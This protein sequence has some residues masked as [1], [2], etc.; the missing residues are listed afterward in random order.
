MCLLFLLPWVSN[1]NAQYNHYGEVGIGAPPNNAA[2]LKILD[3]DNYNTTTDPSYDRR[4]VVIEPLNA[5]KGY[6]A[7]PQAA[8]FKVRFKDNTNPTK[9]VKNVI[10]TYRIVNGTA[11]AG[12][13]FSYPAG[14]NTTLDQGTVTITAMQNE[15]P[16]I[17]IPVIDDSIIEADETFSVQLLSAASDG[18]IPSREN[19]STATVFP[20]GPNETFTIVDNDRTDPSKLKVNMSIDNV[21][22]DRGGAARTVTVSLPTGVSISAATPITVNF[23]ALT[24]ATASDYA[25]SATSVQLTSTDP[26]KTITVTAKCN[27]TVAT[28]HTADLAATLNATAVI[29][30][31]GNL[32]V[33]VSPASLALTIKKTG[34]G[35]LITGVTTVCFGETVTLTAPAGGTSWQWYKNGTAI[36]TNGTSSTYTTLATEAAGTS[37]SYTVKVTNSFGCERTSNAYVVTVNPKPTAP[38]ISTLSDTDICGTG[39][40]VINASPATPPAGVSYQWYKDGSPL[41][42]QTGGSLTV[43]S[44][45]GTGAYTVRATHTTGCYSDASPAITFT[46]Q[47]G[48]ATPKPVIAPNPA[49]NCGGGAI[50][51]ATA[52]SGSYS[53]SATYIWYKR[54]GGAGG[55]VTEVYRTTGSNV[56]LADGGEYTVIVKDP[57]CTS[58]EADYVTVTKNVTTPLAQPVIVKDSRPGTCQGGSILLEITNAATYP[59]GTTFQWYRD[60]VGGGAIAGAVGIVHAA[61]VTGK[62]WA[63]A[64]SANGLCTSGY[65]EADKVDVTITGTSTLTKPVIDKGA[66]AQYCTGGTVTLSVTAASQVAGATYTW[67]SDKRG[68]PI[69][70]GTSCHANTDK[71]NYWVI[72]SKDGCPGP[73]SEKTYVTKSTTTANLAAPVLSSNVVGNTMCEDGSIE[74][75]AAG[76]YTN[77]KYWWFLDNV[78][79]AETTANVYNAIAAG[80]YTVKVVSQ[81]G[82]NNGCESPISNEITVNQGSQTQL[83]QPTIKAVDDNYDA[84]K[85]GTVTLYVTNVQAGVTYQWYNSVDGKITGATG[86]G[87]S[88]AASKTADYWV[89]ATDGTCQSLPSG[90][91]HVTV[92]SAGTN[93]PVKPQ[94]KPSSP[95]TAQFCT[96]GSVTL[97]VDNAATYT[98]HTYQWH[99]EGLGIISGETGASIAVSVEDKYWVVVTDNNSGCQSVA[100]E[101][102]TVTKSATTANLDTPVIAT[103]GGNTF[104]KTNGTSSGSVTI[105]VTNMTD[106]QPAYNNGDIKFQWHSSKV[107]AIAGATEPTYHASVEATYWVV[108]TDVNSNC[109][110]KPSNKEDITEGN[111]VNDVAQPRIDTSGGVTQICT[112][113]SMDLTA[114]E[115]ASGNTYA[116]GVSFKWYRNGLEIAGK[117]GSVINI[118]EN[119]NYTVVAIG[120]CQSLPSAGK[121]ITIGG[122]PAPTVTI[123][124][125]NSNFT[126][127]SGG[128][129]TLEA[130]ALPAGAYSYQWYKDGAPHGGPVTPGNTLT[131]NQAGVYTVVAINGTCRSLQAAP[132]ANVVSSGG[133]APEQPKVVPFNGVTHICAGGSVELKA[134]K[135][136]NSEYL[137]ASDYTFIWFNNGTIVAGE[138]QAIL[139]ATTGGNYTVKVKNDCGESAESTPAVTVTGPDAG[140]PVLVKPEIVADPL[141]AEMCAN[142]SVKLTARQSTDQA[143]YTG[144][145]TYRWFKDGVYLTTTTAPT[146]YIQATATGKY[147][148]KVSLGACTSVISDGKDVINKTGGNVPYTPGIDASSNSICTN[149]MVIL[150]TDVNIAGATYEWYRKDDGTMATTS[151]PSYSAM[152]DGTYYVIVVDGGCRSLPSPDET[153]IPGGGPAQNAPTIVSLGGNQVCTNGAVALQATAVAPATVTKYVW[154]KDGAEVG[155]T[156]TNIYY[157]V[158]GGTYTVAVLEGTCLSKQ[159]T[160]GVVIT[161]GTDQAAGKPVISGVSNEICDNVAIKLTATATAG[162]DPITAYDWYLDGAFKATT[163][164]NEYVAKDAGT[165]TVIA[166]SGVGANAC[167]S[168]PSAGYTVNKTTGTACTASRIELVASSTVNEGQNVTLTAKLKDGYVANGAI[169]VDLS[170]VAGGTNP[171]AEFGACT[172]PYNGH[173]DFYYAGGPNVT[174]TIADGTSEA[175]LV[176][177][178]CDD[179]VAEGEEDFAI[180]GKFN[181]TVVGNSPRVITI[182]DD[183]INPDGTLELTWKLDP[184]CIEGVISGVPYVTKGNPI[185]YIVT[186]VHP[187]KFPVEPVKVQNNVTLDISYSGAAGRYT[188]VGSTTI[189][190]GNSSEVVTVPTIPDNVMESEPLSSFA[191][192]ASMGVSDPETVLIHWGP[193]GGKPDITLALAPV[194][195]A[196]VTEGDSFTLTASVDGGFLLPQ[197]ITLTLSDRNSGAT[198][199]A[200]SG[201]DYDLV[202]SI[203][204]PQNSSSANITINTI[205]NDLFDGTRKLQLNATADANDVAKIN[206]Q[207]PA[208]WPAPLADGLIFDNDKPCLTITSDQDGLDDVVTLANITVK[209]DN[210]TPNSPAVI[211]ALQDAMSGNILGTSYTSLHSTFPIT[212]S[213]GTPSTSFALHSNIGRPTVEQMITIYNNIST[214]VATFG[215]VTYSI[216]P[217]TV[218]IGGNPA[219]VADL[220]CYEPLSVI[221][222]DDFDQDGL[223]NWLERGDSNNIFHCTE[224][225]NGNGTP[226]EWDAYDPNADDDGDG[227][228]NWVE[229]ANRD[230]NPYNDYA[231]PQTITSVNGVACTPYIKG[232]VS[233]LPNFANLDSDGDGVPDSVEKWTD[234]PYDDNEG[235]INIHPALSF[236]DDG[237]GNDYLYIENIEKYTDNL[238]TVFDRQGI[239]VFEQRNYTNSAGTGTD[240]F[241]GV[242][243]KGRKVKKVPMGT[244][245]VVV[246]YVNN[247]GQKKHYTKAVEIRY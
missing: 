237:V 191:F 83:D 155:R 67:Y 229:D 81:S 194:A 139:H 125:S 227:I 240:V 44:A 99:R 40:A 11:T 126:L 70:T 119:G 133:T 168:Q 230:G 195:P 46:F 196:G 163:V 92:A 150:T 153:I 156:N 164:T 131:V 173:S 8:Q 50:L 85:G 170:V 114:V 1:L 233:C 27:S 130:N 79:V 134:V 235:E 140:A 56:F 232:L 174:L 35:N 49:S 141:N 231:K 4:R 146:S 199:A 112:G 186:V 103:E 9:A 188:P 77:V 192:S 142:G 123:K 128:S 25:Y 182:V 242:P 54:V 68:G 117:T 6:E 21:N 201:V 91:K 69:N 209:I 238:V 223:P 102:V 239:V 206:T 180:E 17:S 78:K 154:F 167:S 198:D 73:A 113:G 224:D 236:N 145:V 86:I 147:T 120:T 118:T 31:I 143:Q 158:G 65:N 218:T 177:S 247:E 3:D 22:L 121:Q 138:N 178:T 72:V 116:P 98:D 213:P 62:Y 29:P 95:Y 208:A 185:K 132:A 107:G 241:N 57:A 66:T 204:I 36:T 53:G 144:A 216:V 94:I 215:E 33:P 84:C 55:T 93:A 127:C 7:G 162:S 71:D 243:N 190:A 161:E 18:D 41:A 193:M 172:P 149:G 222:S 109:Q 51:T 176:I 187:T 15:S 105:K 90:S 60:G 59:A 87:A 152:Q 106:F 64:V 12:A 82:A 189:L 111:T 159:S 5:S 203:T 214:F 26:T 16:V 42:G 10:V 47:S 28:S 24:G 183:D 80:K 58:V 212:L 171:A 166:R 75:T 124:D 244:Y 2:T 97:W 169:N 197:A 220:S 151:V 228:P 211:F 226:N 148:V 225:S 88:H 136:D 48:T 101:R 219:T 207:L 129:V 23:A 202:T 32:N 160:P 39:T 38:T 200:I 108:V 13:D 45:M 30:A 76:T 246:E 115:A 122:G 14:Y 74:L 19:A 37:P 43:T 165:Y 221:I 137:P 217:G 135:G 184:A 181:G 157:A 179:D 234:K 89:V 245:F 104:C 34:I 96:G 175:N 205:D 52:S 110:S 100:S 210:F 63:V 20:L 61:D